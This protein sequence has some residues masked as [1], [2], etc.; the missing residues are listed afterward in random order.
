MLK[1]ISE[2]CTKVFAERGIIQKNKTGIYIYGFE[3][4]WSTFF[5]VICILLTGG[6]LGWLTEAVLF[7][8]FFMPIR[9][10]AGGYHA[11]SYRNCFLL[12]NLIAD[13]CIVVSKLMNALA[14]PR[15][16]IV[17][18]AWV[19]LAYIW[20]EA[21]VRFKKHPLKSETVKKCRSYAH[22]L[23]LLEAVAL[24][25]MYIFNL[26][27]IS[28]TAITTYVVAAMIYIAVRKEERV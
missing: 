23:I 6:V 17:I 18:G 22:H 21:P 20:K 1:K 24:G 5:C 28:I 12:T 16:M 25:C 4:F 27:I 15:L 7:L 14:V 11:Q 13:S 26:N 19:M 3:L 2:H 8:L 10:F 9:T